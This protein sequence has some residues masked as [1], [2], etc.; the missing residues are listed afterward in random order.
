M[1]EERSSRIDLDDLARLEE[2]RDHLLRSLRDIEREHA[3]GDMDQVDYEALKD[4][5]TVRAADVLRAIEA[6]TSKLENGRRNRMSRTRGA[7]IF[8]GVI[9]FAVIAGFTVAKTS[10]QRGDNAITGSAGPLR[11]QLAT[12]QPLSFQEPEKGIK[13]YAKILETAPDNVEALTYQGWAMVR[14][15]R[16]EEA[17]KN[18]ARVVELEPDY[19][20]VRVFRAVIAT[21]AGDFAT[22]ATEVSKFYANNPGPMAIQVMQSQ[23]LERKI[24]FGLLSPATT[25][26]WQKAAA[27]N[28]GKSQLDTS[29]YATLGTCLDEALADSPN[30][31]DALISRAFTM[32]GAENPDPK[33]ALQL[34]ETALGF[35]PQNPNALLMRASLRAASNDIAEARSDL[36]SLKKLERPTISFLIGGPEQVE[37]VLD[38][39]AQDQAAGDQAESSVTTQPDQSSQPDIPN[40]S[41]G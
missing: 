12:C 3:A 27:A 9:G 15:E 16:I 28:E 10:G 33:K 11:E 4:D 34:V 38:Q 39:T 40:R 41:G 30:D 32:V 8:A 36:E 24:F 14:A 6:G 5:Y 17:G 1:V 23:G 37:A 35:E 21:R 13:C 22:A 19:P 20:D 18:F 26:C 25:L 7:V 29:F 31:T 2:E